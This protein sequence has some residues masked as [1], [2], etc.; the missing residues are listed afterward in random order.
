M[1]DNSFLY[2]P[3]KLMFVKIICK[4]TENE[5]FFRTDVNGG[6]FFDKYFFEIN[7]KKIPT[8][9]SITLFSSDGRL[10]FNKKIYT[11]IRDDNDCHF[12]EFSGIVLKK[13]KNIQGIFGRFEIPFMFS[14]FDKVGGLIVR[15]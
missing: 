12:V 14:G 10:S 1:S 2:V 13:A 7:G 9:K 8:I 15:H 11:K 4:P 3:G 5:R 6:A